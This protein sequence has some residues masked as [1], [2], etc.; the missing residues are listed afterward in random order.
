MKITKNVILGYIRDWVIGKKKNA[1]FAFEMEAIRIK[2]G[3]FVLIDITKL[4]KDDIYVF[5]I[6]NIMRL[7]LIENGGKYIDD[8]RINIS[9]LKKFCKKHKII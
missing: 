8:N 7:F 5:Y 6:D 1:I 9:K 2:N 4:K 3:K